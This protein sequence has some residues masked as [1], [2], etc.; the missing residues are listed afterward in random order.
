MAINKT[1]ALRTLHEL[2]WALKIPTF[3]KDNRVR[4]WYGEWL[5]RK[6]LRRKK[7]IILHRNWQ[8]PL[9]A[10][11]EI[12]LI[13]RDKE[14]LVFIEV[15]ARSTNSLNT[16]YHSLNRK[17]RQAITSACRDFLRMGY[18]KFPHFRFDVI[19]VD[20]GQEGNQIF[21]HENVSLFP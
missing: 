12:D 17:K 15:R 18:Q 11:R 5:A 3:L 20:L 6:H 14:S 9:D 7:L 16:G 1:L 8:S 21:H 4:G 19:E 10:R 13:V 2:I